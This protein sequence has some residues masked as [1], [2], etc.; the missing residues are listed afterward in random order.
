MLD[1]DVALV[2]KF[3][4]GPTTLTA[5]E[6]GKLYIAARDAYYNTSAA[7]L[8]DNEFDV[9]EGHLRRIDPKAAALKVVGAPVREGKVALPYWMGS[10]DKIRDDDRAVEKWKKAYP[11]P[12]QYVVSDKLDGN[13]A[14]LVYAANGT[15][16]IYT[17][18]DGVTGQDVSWLSNYITLPS[19]KA[20]REALNAAKGAVAVRGE[21]IIP[22][23]L[24]RAD[25][26]ANARNVAA[27]LINSKR[28][29]DAAMVRKLAFVAYELVEPRLAPSSA[30]AA[31]EGAGFK[32]AAYRVMDAA[33][34]TMEALSMHLVDRRAKSPY[35]VDGIVIAHDTHHRVIKGKNPKYAFAFKSMLTHEE[36]EVIVTGVEWNVSK[37]GYMKPTVMFEPV[38]L[39]GV[40]IA[41]ATGFNAAFIVEHKIGVGAKIRITRSGDV[42]PYITGV[43]TPAR[44]VDLPGGDDVEWNETR[45]DLRLKKTAHE[46]NAALATKRMEHFAKSLGMRGVAG[47]M[48]ARIYAGGVRS[49]RDLLNVTRAQ[50]LAMDGIQAKSADSLLA[51]VAKI[52]GGV[53]CVDAMTASNAFGHG[54]GTRKLAVI[55]AAF[56]S[57]TGTKGSMPTA[58][59]LAAVDGLGAKT[60]AA[61][62]E[63]LPDFHAFMKETGLTCE[64]APTSPPAPSGPSGFAGITVVFSGVRDKDLEARIESGG[65]KVSTSVSKNTM[66]VV[67]KDPASTSGKVETARKLG[68]PV[69]DMAAFVKK[70]A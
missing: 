17:R 9:L 70:Y 11:D 32:V 3:R 35:E 37:D 16:A 43:A 36:A 46:G 30:M 61:F 2:A 34:L 60:A 22:R 18:G 29:I 5:S 20:V 1:T 41:R 58:A 67:A 15:V 31:V 51:E 8:E 63:A 44:V 42:I 54:F 25:M 14:M 4:A 69:M 49:V 53:P 26:G 39:S 52:K 62:L 55:V 19:V 12:A 13:S 21:L 45:V 48:V 57:V 59:D 50:L 28:N 6:A 24:W 23:A 64:G 66:V 40:R 68:I 10:L 7:I 47:G 65:G 27:G 56:P 38:Q 33:A